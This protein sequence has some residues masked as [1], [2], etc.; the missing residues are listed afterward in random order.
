MTIAASIGTPPEVGPHR[1]SDES[2]GIR[3]RW[4]GVGN[5]AVA[6]LSFLKDAVRCGRCPSLERRV[7]AFPLVRASPRRTPEERLRTR[8]RPFRIEIHDGE[9]GHL[10]ATH[11][12]GWLAPGEHLRTDSILEAL[13]PP[14]TRGWARI[15]PA[16]LAH[17]AVVDGATPGADPAA[18]TPAPPRCRRPCRI[19]ARWER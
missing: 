14:V 8:G 17:A 2:S 16:D 15:V 3:H 1:R 12:T 11:E 4:K 10:T 5:G 13:S 19:L 6:L 18:G 7:L 9:T